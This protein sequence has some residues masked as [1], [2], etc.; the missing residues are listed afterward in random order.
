MKAKEGTGSPEARVPSGCGS[1]GMG[2]ESR[3]ESS[4]RGR[5]MC[6]ALQLYFLVTTS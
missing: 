5:P 6:P 3:L 1:P 2:A 4:A